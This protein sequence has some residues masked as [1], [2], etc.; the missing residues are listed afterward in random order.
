MA[1]GKRSTRD[2]RLRRCLFTD[3]PLARVGLTAREAQHRGIATRI[4]H[5]AHAHCAAHRTARAGRRSF[6]KVLVG[7][8]G[9]RILG[10]R[11]ARLGSRRGDGGR[12]DGQCLRRR[13][14]PMVRDAVI[15]HLTFCPEGL[16]PRCWLTWRRDQRSMILGG[17]QAAT[18]LSTMARRISFCTKR[19]KARALR[20]VPRPP[21]NTAHRSSAGE[22]PLT[23]SAVRT[24][25][26]AISG[27]NIHSDATVRPRLP[28]TA[29]R[30]HPL[31]HS[32]AIEFFP[33]SR[34]SPARLG[35]RPGRAVGIP[36]CWV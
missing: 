10:L 29:K 6:M 12:A 30:E 8:G 2:R 32:P 17:N 25:P 27:A 5:A 15:A 4:A 22:F 28:M 13:P 3:P 31:P 18:R 26:D 9:G 1:G 33:A 16:E 20:L 23:V 21:G 24:A 34:C 7:A 36:R 35:E 11:L 19:A 14:I